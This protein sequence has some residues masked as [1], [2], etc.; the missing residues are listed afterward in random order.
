MKE[1]KTK[2]FREIL[3]LEDL[4]P[5]D[6]SAVPKLSFTNPGKTRGQEQKYC[7]HF[8]LDIEGRIF[9]GNYVEKIQDHHVIHEEM[10]DKGKITGKESL[11][12]AEVG[13]CAFGGGILKSD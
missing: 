12:Q 8:L 13:L 10:N 3:I 1:I 5:S 2:I 7:S 4:G 6:L 11:C 9:K